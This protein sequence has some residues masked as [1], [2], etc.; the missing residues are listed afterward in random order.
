M[1]SRERAEEL[2]VAERSMRSNSHT[3]TLFTLHS[4]LWDVVRAFSMVSLSLSPSNI[5]CRGSYGEGR[6][7]SGRPIKSDGRQFSVTRDLINLAVRPP[8]LLLHLQSF[9]FFLFFLASLPGTPSPE[10]SDLSPLLRPLPLLLLLLILLL[11]LLLL[12]LLL[13]ASSSHQVPPSRS[14][15]LSLPPLHQGTAIFLPVPREKDSTE[16][17]I[18]IIWWICSKYRCETKMLRQTSFA[19]GFGSTSLTSFDRL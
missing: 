2:A 5:I 17:T 12:P 19:V 15:S 4:P 9:L 18:I 6:A 14:K 11:L 10:P 13:P 3:H 16:A 7:R 8:L 1:F